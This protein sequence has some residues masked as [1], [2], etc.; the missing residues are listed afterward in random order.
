MRKAGVEWSTIMRM[1]G[2]KTPEMFER[3]NSVAEE[4]AEM[5]FRRLKE[6]LNSSTVV[7]PR[8]VGAEKCLTGKFVSVSKN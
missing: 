5:A 8:E 4:D 7:P 1:A 3:Y 6:Y 2:H